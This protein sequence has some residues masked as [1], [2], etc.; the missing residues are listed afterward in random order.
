M[1]AAA[2]ISAGEFVCA[3]SS[4]YAVVGADDATYTFLGIAMEDK[5]NSEGDNGD[6]LIRIRRRGCFLMTATSIAQANVG[7]TMYIRGAATF[8]ES[9]TNY[10]VCG[11][12][13]NYVS[14]TQGWLSID[15]AV[16]APLSPSSGDALTLSD[17]G[18][19]FAAADNTIAEQM[20]AL[21]GDLKAIPIPAYTGW[22]KDGADKT[23]PGPKLELNYACRIKRAYFYV[24]TAPSADKTLT[25]KFGSDTL[26][27]IAGTDQHGE[28]ESLNIAVAANTDFF[29]NASGLLVNETAA[30]SAANLQGYLLVARDD[31]E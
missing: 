30:G 6:L 11:R 2:S 9:A 24:G 7:A 12:L 13:V 10:V 29:S 3:D 19:F 4:G 15:E 23:V 8:D 14:A 26:A 20:Q 17:T 16:Y 21:A 27:S 31:G 18:D 25:I 22:T 1:A 28:G 5:D